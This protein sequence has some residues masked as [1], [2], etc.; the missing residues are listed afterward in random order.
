MAIFWLLTAFMFHGLLYYIDP[1][2]NYIVQSDSFRW[3]QYIKYVLLAALLPFAFSRHW[4]RSEIIPVFAISVL[5]IL[6]LISFNFNFDGRLLFQFS[7][8]IAAFYLAPA[9]IEIW[10]T[11]EKIYRS[12]LAVILVTAIAIAVELIFGQ[13]EAFS[14]S[15]FRAIGP[16]INPNNTGI[17]LAIFGT[18][19]HLYQKDRTRNFGLLGGTLILIILTGSKTA[20]A[21]YF[22]AIFLLIPWRWRV[23]VLLAVAIV[24]FGFSGLVSNA[25]SAFSLR[26]FSAESAMMR[27]ND[28]HELLGILSGLTP[29]QIF[30]GFSTV[31]IIDNAYIDIWSFGGAALVSAFVLVQVAAVIRCIRTQNR[32]LLI[33]HA[34]FA[35]AMLTTNVPR[36][37]PTGYIYWA[38]VGISFLYVPPSRLPA[39]SKSL[40][41]SYEQKYVL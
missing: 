14:R 40:Q 2:Q 23:L 25:F 38:L 15:G 24:G 27:I 41:N 6:S 34:L 26:E 39:S 9:L 28:F 16:F 3:F 33:L 4:T 29:T 19:A 37:W 7:A 10:D 17:V 21:L 12:S 11:N 22:L 5:P 36:L 31:S 35:F 20:M 18:I 13:L 30:W 1:S 8:A 32:G